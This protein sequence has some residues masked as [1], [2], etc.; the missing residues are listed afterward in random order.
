VRFAIGA[1]VLA[2]VCAGVVAA[3]Q[4]EFRTEASGAPKITH[5]KLFR[6]AELREYW[7]W[8]TIEH[9]DWPISNRR[10]R[11]NPDDLYPDLVD[12]IQRR[13]FPEWTQPTTTEE[14]DR[15]Y[16]REPSFP[17][18]YRNAVDHWVVLGPKGEKVH[19]RDIVRPHPG[20]WPFMLLER[21][22]KPPIGLTQLTWKAHD[23]IHGYGTVVVTVDLLKDKGP[24]YEIVPLPPYPWTGRLPG[25]KKWMRSNCA[26]DV[27]DLW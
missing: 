25:V 3:G 16:T 21:G 18:P 11:Q 9:E 2:C 12:P 7:A 5:V 27:P 26:S 24:N 15:V 14:L 23:P 4:G 20:G 10:F 22:I 6:S 13:Q 17:A 19:R 8:V 1:V